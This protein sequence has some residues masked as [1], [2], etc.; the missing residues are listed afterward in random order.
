MPLVNGIWKYDENETV[1]PT[2]SEHLNK[3]GDSVRSAIAASAPPDTSWVHIP[4]ASGVTGILRYRQV[5]S[6]VEVQVEV[7]GSFP[8]GA[9][10]LNAGTLPTGICPSG[11]RRGGASMNGST[12]GSIGVTATGFV[13]LI[14]SSGATRT[15]TD[16]SC[17]YFL[18]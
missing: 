18:G 7:S 13:F 11:N 3:L 16:G 6:Q 1:S 5:G 17:L 8:V 12:T 10:Q 2:Y 15:A 9:T 14:H 4:K